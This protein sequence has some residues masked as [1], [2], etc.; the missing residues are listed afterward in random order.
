MSI[1]ASKQPDDDNSKVPAGV[2]GAG[3]FT[4]PKQD[5]S[6]VPDPIR[7]PLER[8]REWLYSHNDETHSYT[9][10]RANKRYARAKDVDR[11]FAQE[12]DTFST[13]LITYCAS[14]PSGE[15][16]AGHASNFYPRAVT[17]KRR[18]ILKGLEVYNDFAGVA[19]RS[20]KQRDSTGRVPGPN[21][22]TTHAHELLWIPGEVSEADFRGLIERHIAAVPGA[23]EENNPLD[24]A[25]SVR[26]H[27]S[28]DVQTPYRTKA[29]GTD[30][31]ARRGN[32][33]ALPQELGANLPLLQSTYDARGTPHYV[34]EWCANMRLGTDDSLTTRGL[35][36]FQT[37]GRFGE[38]ADDMH[39]ERKLR[40]AHGKAKALSEA[41]GVPDPEAPQED[42]RLNEQ[43]NTDKQESPPANPEGSHSGKGENTASGRDKSSGKE[44]T[45][46]IETPG[47]RPGS[48][49][50]G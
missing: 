5:T 48:L 3:V 42:T 1:T 26:T 21:P 43:A 6:G 41:L 31:D 18:R 14:N 23:T 32:T 11:Y 10:K 45:T 34:E 9:R 16:I 38:I 46:V 2:A 33:T 8:F 30:I 19:I 39:T 4:G 40:K 36:R 7:P 17:R 22:P 49:G 12:Y 35:S 47:K 24:K 50:I 25:V 27:E 15:S 44:N 29:R 37:L 20:P 13:A 28:D